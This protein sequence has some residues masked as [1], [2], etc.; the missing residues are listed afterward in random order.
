MMEESASETSLSSERQTIQ[1]AYKLIH[2]FVSMYKKKFA[3]NVK[4]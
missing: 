4:R 1:S 3:E 2:I